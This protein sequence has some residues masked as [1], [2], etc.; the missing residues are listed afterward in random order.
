MRE[1]A[2][3]AVV[4]LG[5]STGTGPTP[6][7]TAVLSALREA[8]ARVLLGDARPDERV[9]PGVRFTRC[10]ITDDAQ[11]AACLRRAAEQF[12]A[13]DA[14]INLGGS[15]AGAGAERFHWLDSLNTGVVSAAI[16]ARAAHPHLRAAGGAIVNLTSDGTVRRSR[17]LAPVG[18]AALVELTRSIAADFAEDGIRVNS[19][20]PAWTWSEVL[21][22]FTSDAADSGRGTPFHPLGRVADPAE[23]AEVV[24]FLC[25]PSSAFITGSDWAVA[26]GYTSAGLVSGTGS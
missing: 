21:D 11:V 3:K 23:V 1:L 12:G 26:G 18:K 4:V 19:V 9:V 8:G 13:L 25:S 5:G 14:V 20:S 6:I 15:P 7:G 16:A 17:W 10:E 2:G 22:Q 24:L